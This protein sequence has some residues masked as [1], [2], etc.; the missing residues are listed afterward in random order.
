MKRGDHRR[1]RTVGRIKC[2]GGNGGDPVGAHRAGPYVWQLVSICLRVISYFGSMR[3]QPMAE[4]A[5][6]NEA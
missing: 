2:G 1:R 6:H 4:I 3:R 5:R